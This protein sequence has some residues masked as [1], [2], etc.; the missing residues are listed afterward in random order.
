MSTGRGSQ[1]GKDSRLSGELCW[2]QVTNY[3]RG[4]SLSPSDILSVRIT[5][6]PDYGVLIQTSLTFSD[7]FYPLSD[8]RNRRRP[9]D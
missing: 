6:I 3:L 4:A 9:T 8:A 7:F 2:G 1:G 5:N